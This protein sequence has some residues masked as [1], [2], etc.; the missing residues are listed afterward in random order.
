[1]GNAKFK[2][3]SVESESD[4]VSSYCV[5]VVGENKISGAID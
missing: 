5:R 1:M 3:V 2:I 4:G